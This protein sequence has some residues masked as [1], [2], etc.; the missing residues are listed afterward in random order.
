MF[1][2]WSANAWLASTQNRK[3]AVARE[4]WI[5]DPH[6][7]CAAECAIQS[8]RDCVL[9]S[10]V[11]RPSQQPWALLRNPVGILEQNSRPDLFWKCLWWREHIE[12][13]PDLILLRFAPLCRRGEDKLLTKCMP[14]TPGTIFKAKPDLSGL[15][16]VRF[17][18][19]CDEDS[20]WS[21]TT[22]W[23]WL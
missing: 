18:Q 4:V 11:A 2:G 14:L 3:N 23:L 5:G 17:M 22:F 6:R 16:C 12:P 9:Q 13:A 21:A 8:R 15:V 20:L 7:N 1:V 10:R 19:V